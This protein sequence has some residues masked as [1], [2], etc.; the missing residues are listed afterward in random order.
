MELYE[1]RFWDWRDKDV[2]EHVVLADD[3]A[4]AA[5]KIEA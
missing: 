2:Y 5:M 3:M 1:V 4:R